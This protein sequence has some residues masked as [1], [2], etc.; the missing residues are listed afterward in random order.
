LDR[1]DLE[2]TDVAGESSED[3]LDIRIEDTEPSADDDSAAIGEDATSPA[4]G[5]VLDN[6]TESADTPSGV[7]FTDTGASYGSFV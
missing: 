2:V 5:N 4:T 1:F 7:V 6:D 3:T